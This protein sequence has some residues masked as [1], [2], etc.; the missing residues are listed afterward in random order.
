MNHSDIAFTVTRGAFHC[1][2]C[3]RAIQLLTDTGHKFSVRKL[4]RADLK[5]L[6]KRN[7]HT[8]VPMIFHGVKFIGGFDSL[9]VYL[10]TP[11]VTE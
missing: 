5:E 3:D 8:T 2:W 9:E 4:S 6:G 1:P 11:P 10:D 7:N